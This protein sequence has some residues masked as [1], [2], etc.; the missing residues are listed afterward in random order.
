MPIRDGG[1]NL[2]FGVKITADGSVYVDGVRAAI[3]ANEQLKDSV[4]GSGDA[5]REA[6]KGHEDMAG[7]VFK[8]TGAMEVAKKTIEKVVELYG[9]MKEHT[10]AAQQSQA[11]LEAVLHATNGAAGQTVDTIGHLADEMQRLTVFDDSQIKDAATALLTFDKIAGDTFN[12]VIKLSADMASTGRGDL[13]TWVTV[14]GKAGQDPAASI[15]LVERALGKL[16][17]ALK[18]AIQNAADFNDKARAQALLLDEVERRVGGTAQESYRGLTRQIEGTKK[19]WDDLLRAMGEEIFNAK[20]KEASFFETTLR[21]MTENFKTRMGIMRDAWN[22]LPA[23]LRAIFG[24]TPQVTPQQQNAADIAQLQ[25][26]R[27]AMLNAGQSTARIDAEIE[28]LQAMGRRLKPPGAGV[29][30][31]QS[32]PGFAPSLSQ[33][34]LTIRQRQA[35]RDQDV[36]LHK[37]YI[38]HLAQ[39][40]QGWN[41]RLIE[42]EGERHRMGLTSNS[43]YYATVAALEQASLS[44]RVSTLRADLEDEKKLLGSAQAEAR[45]ANTAKDKPEEIAAAEA[46]VLAIRNQIAITTADLA[47]AE[48]RWGDA[49]RKRA[50]QQ[51]VDDAA[52]IDRW[53]Q[54]TRQREDIQRT[55]NQ[56]VGAL[57]QEAALVG[58]TEEEVRQANV[59]R[60]LGRQYDQKRLEIERQLADLRDKPNKDANDLQTMQDLQD[61]LDALPDMF[62][63]AAEKSRAAIAEIF[64]KKRWADLFGGAVTVMSDTFKA[65]WDAVVNHTG[66]AGKAMRDTLKREFFDWL[67]AQFAKPF[68]LNVIAQVAN[69]M[70]LGGIAQAATTAAGGNTIGSAFGSMLSGAAGSAMSWLGG[71]TGIS[72]AWQGVQAGYIAQSAYMSGAAEMAPQ[73]GTI[74]G[75]FGSTLASITP[76]LGYFAIALAG[77][78]AAASAYAQG[79]RI[80]GGGV[81][82]DFRT[83]NPVAPLF[84]ATQM[85]RTYRALGFNDQ[86]AAILSGSSF[87]T[88]L[89]GHGMTH[90]D[91]NGL[92]GNF[93]ATGATGQN[94]QDYSQRGGFFSSDR[95]WTENSALTFGQTGFLASLMEPITSAIGGLASILGVNAGSALAGYSHPFNVQLT[96]NGKPRSEEDIRKEFNDVLGHVLQEQVE[97]ILRTGGKGALADYVHN[98]Q[99]TGAEIA[100]TVQDVLNLVKATDDLGK[101]I[102]F[103]ADGPLEALKLHLKDLDKSVSDA[104]QAFTEAIAGGDPSKILAAEQTLTSAVMSRYQ[105]EIQMVE[106]LRD[107]IR[108]VDEAAY[109]FAINIAQRINAVGG[110]RDVG[111]IAM[112]RATTLRGS[113]SNDTNG[114]PL[115]LRIQDLQ[116]YVGAIDT[117]YQARSSAIMQDAQKQAAQIN[118][119]NQA[120]AQSAQAQAQALQQQLDLASKWKDVLAS[121]GKM[122]DDMRLS[123]S[124]PLGAIGR[125]QMAQGDVQAL[126]ATYQGATGEGKID[127]A[128]KLMGA[129]QTYRGLGQ[130]AFQR[131]SGEWQGVYNEIMRDLTMIQADAKGPA[132]QAVDLQRQILEAQNAANAYAGQ[133]ADA[134]Q[135]AAGQMAALNEEAQGYYTWAEAAGTELYARQRAEY[136]EQLNTITGGVQV[137]LFIADLNKQMLEVLKGIKARLDGVIDNGPGS[138]TSGPPGSPGNPIPGGPDNGSG[139]NKSATTVVI[140]VD[141]TDPLDAILRNATRIKRAIEN[142]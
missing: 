67:Y 17:P 77:A 13:Q 118:A 131:P 44:S 115:N 86:W 11:R 120:A 69:G 102:T 28:R 100:Q 23:G 8:G 138:P 35:L 104:D 57:T 61:E 119:A 140:N 22:S 12:R 68:V 126:L 51:Y 142:A 58:K 70:G 83:N 27:A 81:S 99:G 65:G 132:E 103:L 3:E 47:D 91:A 39:I 109:Q 66:N 114:T 7:A 64:S 30:P 9:E 62:A 134:T 63:R 121:A 107:N 56:S 18:V 75:Q 94:W 36:E 78:A 95:R 5:A 97:T 88:R 112:G 110:S 29:D 24:D 46:K 136:V 79:F 129:L 19:A 25:G 122:I 111:A 141:G 14:L 139:I 87:A 98:L 89:F 96:D 21:T 60:E 125:T 106:Q 124:N 101:T 42:I 16:D 20:S 33:D 31:W 123:S 117:W 49:E 127:A 80:D 41:Q 53:V 133:T 40:E 32:E 43:A 48:K 72:S 113:V 34:P 26:V 135:I 45:R 38:D 1:G 10:E 15:G 90:A 50:A 85:D 4:K 2:E 37:Q 93:N 6:G 130:E 105:E 137:D 59:A 84:M 128:N 116:S 82:H 73:F 108:G 74:A 92:S 54:I 52:M 71:V 55:L 76:Y